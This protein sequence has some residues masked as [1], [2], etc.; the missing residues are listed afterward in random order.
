MSETGEI[1][2]AR[3]RS[4]MYR[5]HGTGQIKD[6][7][8]A[9][10]KKIEGGA[11]KKGSAVIEAWRSV[12]GDEAKE[13]TLPVSLKK[14]TLVVVVENSVWLY[15]LTLEK[16]KVLKK[17]NEKYEGRKKAEQIRFRVG[18]VEEQLL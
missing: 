4:F 14:G 11:A 8:G 2:E 5:R 7:V 13:H 3:N 1:G 9:F 18:V 6:V 12:V 16:D 15:K 17:F 10:I